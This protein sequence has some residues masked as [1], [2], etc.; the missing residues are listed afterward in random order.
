VFLAVE[1]NKLLNVSVL[2]STFLL[3]QTRIL[4]I[5][6]NSR[7]RWQKSSPIKPIFVIDLHGSDPSRPYDIDFN[8]E[9]YLIQESNRYPKSPKTQLRNEGH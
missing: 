7:T 4:R 3:H 1:L 8:L 5:T 2:Y 6:M 9:W